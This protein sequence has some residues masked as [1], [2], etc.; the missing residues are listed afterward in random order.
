METTAPPE[1]L[2][3]IKVLVADDNA[4]NRRILEGMLKRW[5]MQAKSVESGDEALAELGAAGS[6]G[7]PYA[8]ILTDMH[9]PGM[10]GFKLVERIRQMPELSTAPIMMLPSS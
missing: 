8:L 10:D 3:G 6:A 7:E 9:M 2:H 5:N 4:T 1:L